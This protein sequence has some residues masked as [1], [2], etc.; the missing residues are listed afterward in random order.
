MW[1]RSE[2]AI[3]L[4]CAVGCA[5]SGAQK[6]GKGRTV[7]EISRSIALLPPT[8]VSI[9][10]VPIQDVINLRVP[11]PD[12]PPQEGS[13]CARL[14]CNASL[15]SRFSAAAPAKELE[16]RWK[17]P[18][19][20]AFKPSNVLQ[21][22]DR[23]LAYGGGAWRLFDL[24]GEKVAD[25]RTGSSPMV[26]D[27]AHGLFYFVNTNGFLAAHKLVDGSEEFYLNP[28]APGQ[29]WPFIARQ[30]N[31]I[32]DL[33][34]ELPQPWRPM[35]VPLNAVLEH[36]D[37]AEEMKINRLKVV[38]NLVSLESLEIAT[39]TIQV[40][41]HGDDVIF[42]IPGRVV[43]SSGDLQPRAGLDGDFVPR[44]IS[45]DESGRIH[46][47]VRTGEH[48]ALWVLTPAG[49]RTASITFKPE[50]GAPLAPPIIG[51]DHRIFLLHS[52]LTAFDAYG[53]LLWERWPRG[54]VVGGG[55]TTDGQLLITDGDLAAYDP[56]GE[57]RILFAL[58][59]VSFITPP[60]MSASGEI[61]VASS[62][63]VYCLA[64]RHE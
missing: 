11:L 44:F 10:A 22:G 34:V 3:V 43:L 39:G 25:G 33:S 2:R 29:A 6:Q 53:D 47:I 55:I 41:M 45:I 51:Y 37:L 12:A 46:L 7:I 5:A 17:V 48:T 14:F 16:V 35:D 38:S 42:A 64:P 49:Q 20:P 57:R 63:S 26:L 15:N 1:A 58:P 59:G 40:A 54:R 36:Q 50:Y 9:A 62:D 4:L 24:S 28:A 30:G 52:G 32:Y 23:V 60:A 18:F 56:Q 13:S 21:G 61:F 31:R 19:T 27:V 8:K